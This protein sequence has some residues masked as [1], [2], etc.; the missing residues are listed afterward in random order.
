MS[1]QTPI[2]NNNNNNKDDD[3]VM[4]QLPDNDI[5]FCI[6]DRYINDEASEQSEAIIYFYP[7]VKSTPHKVLFGGMIQSLVGAIQDFF[8]A[9]SKI[10]YVRFDRHIMAYKFVGT[11]TLAL[12]AHKSIP[13]STII[14]HLDYIYNSFTFYCKS[15]KDINSRETKLNMNRVLA[16]TME[17][18]SDDLYKNRMRSFQ[19]LPYTPLPPSSNRTFLRSSQMLHNIIFPDHLGGALFVK[20][21]LLISTIDLDITKHIIDKI[22]HTRDK[23]NGSIPNDI[24][25]SVYIS[26]KD[27]D[28]LIQYKLEYTDTPSSNSNNFEQDSSNSQ[29]QQQQESSTSTT[30]NASQQ[31][32]IRGKGENDEEPYV[33][34]ELLLLFWANVT[35]A[36]VTQPIQNTTRYINK[37]RNLLISSSEI[38]TLEKDPALQNQNTM[39]HTTISPC[40][41]YGYHFLSYNSLTQSAVA[42][43]MSSE[44]EEVFINT[45]SNIHDTF[46]ENSSISQMFLRNQ[47]GEIFCKKQFEL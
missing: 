15:F 40:H 7:E 36:V 26:P 45:C 5:C 29:Q 42:S 16:E 12:C 22:Q 27:Y 30:N 44:S 38:D 46:E 33:L 21:N 43:G 14:H 3:E 10:D 39:C 1:S 6:F 25:I 28:Q 24:S 19:P 41:T 9:K 11:Y 23:V 35:V 37:I 31:Q 20:S 34:V 2:Q 47:N 32:N 17:I 8:D 13:S 4:L 18:V